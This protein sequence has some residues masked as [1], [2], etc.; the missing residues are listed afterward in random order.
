MAAQPE[1]PKRQMLIQI[2]FDW[3]YMWERTVMA[4][5]VHPAETE[6]ATT[7][8]Y[9]SRAVYGEMSGDETRECLPPTRR[10]R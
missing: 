1:R 9:Y 3:V 6:M 5:S 2:L 4:I 7:P 8:Y 10:P